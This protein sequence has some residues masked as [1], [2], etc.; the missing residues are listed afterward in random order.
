MLTKGSLLVILVLGSWN[1]LCAQ[2]SEQQQA[3]VIGV[4]M[5]FERKIYAI[6]Q[7]IFAKVSMR[8]NSSRIVHFSAP[9]D[10]GTGPNGGFQFD[11]VQQ[12]LNVQGT[13]FGRAVDVLP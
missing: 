10:T 2:T 13:R 12:P 4:K 6:G 9:L 3:V 1:I 5:K 11:V 7:P 8:N